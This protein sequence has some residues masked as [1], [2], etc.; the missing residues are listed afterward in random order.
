[1]INKRFV[2]T[3]ECN[4]AIEKLKTYLSFP[5]SISSILVQQEGKEHTP[6]YYT[7]KT[8]LAAKTRKTDLLNWLSR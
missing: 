6:I 8:L 1:M 5:H 7:G 2:G 4:I 3:S